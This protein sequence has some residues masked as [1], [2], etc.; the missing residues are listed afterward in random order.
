MS[1]TSVDSNL[2]SR[3]FVSVS[4]GESKYV[5]ASRIGAQIE[6]S[7]SINRQQAILEAGIAAC[8]AAKTPA[9]VALEAKKAARQMGF[10]MQA[11]VSEESGRNLKEIKKRIEEMAKK[12]TENKDS[13]DGKDAVDQSLPQPLPQTDQKSQAA[14]APSVPATEAAPAEVPQAS[15]PA[16][17]VQ[18]Q[19]AQVAVAAGDSSGTSATPQAAVNPSVNV[20]V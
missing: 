6:R 3:N 16:A 12:A 13:A 15:L 11:S 8:A 20:Y 9:E 2:M 17:Q 19:P 18:V 14:P 10:A 4:S 1:V 5:K 7:A